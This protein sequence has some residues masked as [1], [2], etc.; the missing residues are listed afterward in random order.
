MCFTFVLKIFHL[1]FVWYAKKK[2]GKT[3]IN[4]L[5]CT[6][7]LVLNYSNVLNNRIYHWYKSQT[8][9]ELNVNLSTEFRHAIFLA[10]LLLYLKCFCT[11]CNFIHIY[12]CVID[13]RQLPNKQELYELVS[14]SKV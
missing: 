11:A 9:G 8:V 3:K 10:A 2:T 6:R 1:S 12:I 4:M 14:S 5:G 13:S 7:R